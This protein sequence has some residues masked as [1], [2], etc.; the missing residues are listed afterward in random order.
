M[1]FN[2]NSPDADKK[3]EKLWH[4]AT[5]EDKLLLNN[6]RTDNN[7]P[8]KF[9]EHFCNEIYYRNQDLKETRTIRK[10]I[11]LSCSKDYSDNK[12]R[13]TALNIDKNTILFRAMPLKRLEPSPKNTSLGNQEQTSSN[14]NG[15]E[16][17]LKDKLVE[18]CYHSKTSKRVWFATLNEDVETLQ[19]TSNN[20]YQTLLALGLE[21]EDGKY[22]FMRYPVNELKLFK[23]TV[24]DAYSDAKFYPSFSEDE[25]GRTV[26]L[27]LSPN[28]Q[29]VKEMV[30]LIPSE[31]VIRADSFEIEVKNL[32]YLDITQQDLLEAV[33]Q[34]EEKM[35]SDFGEPCR[36]W[37]NRRRE[38]HHD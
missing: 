30:H 26:N 14:P 22:L 38:L 21:P 33:K 1:I 18:Y 32:E 10:L 15:T 5:D 12:L 8:E 17:S 9:K 11:R 35:I 4:R 6:W 7:I 25:F 13:K 34:H 29:S 23:P 19:K 37:L 24:F 31:D 27:N 28:N 36:N 16:K 2:H 20:D 3:F